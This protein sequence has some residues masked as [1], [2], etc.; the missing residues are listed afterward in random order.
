MIFKFLNKK[1]NHNVSV[2]NVPG[3]SI[4]SVIIPTYNHAKYL[5]DS[6]SSV[7]SQTFTDFE[8]IIVNDGSTDNTEEIVKQFEDKRIVYVYQKNQDAYNAINN[9][10]K[11]AKGQ[12]IAILND[13]DLYKCDKLK[14]SVKIMEDDREVQAVFSDFDF[15]DDSKK[16]FK[17]KKGAYDNWECLNED[18]SFKGQNNILLD[19]LAGNFLGT[20]SNLICRKSVFDKI[21]YFINIRYTHDYHFFLKLCS[22]CKVYFINKSLFQYRV[23]ESNTLKKSPSAA[24]F[25][26]VLTLLEFFLNNKFADLY[27]GKLD[28]DC[29]IRFFNSVQLFGAERVALFVL[30]FS[31]QIDKNVNLIQEL[32]YNLKNPLRQTM[33]EYLKVKYFDGYN[34]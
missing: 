20:T 4:M 15:I 3:N 21:G 13:D 32:R 33:I 25:E 6:I 26:A 2:N 30:L 14:D 5:V 9:G 16:V 8:L 1:K 11:L 19:L 10:I 22:Q 34:F 28:M 23:N 27:N 29:M 18:T 17:V 12:Y 24:V 7:L 31:L